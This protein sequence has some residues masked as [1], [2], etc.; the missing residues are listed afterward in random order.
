MSSSLQRVLL[1]LQVKTGVN[2]K[3]G[4]LEQQPGAG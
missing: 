2:V 4:A 1:H 3:Q